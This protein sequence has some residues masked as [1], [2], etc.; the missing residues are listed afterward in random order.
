MD[1]PA[2]RNITGPPSN[3]SLRERYV[4]LERLSEFH[5][6]R[7]PTTTDPAGL[8]TIAGLDE[9]ELSYLFCCTS[10]TDSY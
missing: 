4:R 3:V 2:L 8:K 5:G 9:R 6:F 7:V 10:N 1:L